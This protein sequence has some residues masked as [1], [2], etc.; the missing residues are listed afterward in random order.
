MYE[1]IWRIKREL[2][3][4]LICL[5]WQMF[6]KYLGMLELLLPLPD[7]RLVCQGNAAAL[8]PEPCQQQIQLVNKSVFR[9][10][11]D[12][13]SNDRLDPDPDSTSEIEL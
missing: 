9:I 5:V 13:Y 8:A 10:R 1:L 4:N 6:E 2:L 11:V 12:P 3:K 7:Q